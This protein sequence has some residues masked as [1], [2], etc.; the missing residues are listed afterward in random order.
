MARVTVGFRLDP[1]EAEDLRRIAR[2]EGRI[3]SALLRDI[4]RKVIAEQYA[5]GGH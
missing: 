4:V 3:V 1:K 5:G 2:R